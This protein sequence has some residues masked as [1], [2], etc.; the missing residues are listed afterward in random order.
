MNETFLL[1][2]D[3]S[4]PLSGL[5]HLK[6]QLLSLE[7]TQR[8]DHDDT[9]SETGIS[10]NSKK[11]SKKRT[12]YNKIN[13]EI[14]LK[15]IDAVEK[16]GE[17][18]KSAAKRFNVN[19]SSAKSIFQTY[20]KE[21]RVLR[22]TNKNRQN[23]SGQKAV[24][25]DQSPGEEIIKLEPQYLPSANNAMEM[26]G[27][28][29]KGPVLG[30]RQVLVASSTDAVYRNN[31]NILLELEKIALQAQIKAQM[32]EEKMKNVMLLRSI[33]GAED[34]RMALGSQYKGNNNRMR[35]PSFV[36]CSNDLEEFQYAQ[37]LDAIKG[38][39]QKLVANN[40]GLYH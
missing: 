40:S 13:N 39:M 28:N 26:L 12:K 21:G 38:L 36:S 24:S 34:N 15:L 27:G 23:I 29:R 35:I 2:R 14:R 33:L 5:N 19:Y 16:D 30:E 31:N 1:Q 20:R 37:N 9:S 22:K 17:L 3:F 4:T 18:L 7:R 10:S 11:I 25:K 32:E 6:N 8:F